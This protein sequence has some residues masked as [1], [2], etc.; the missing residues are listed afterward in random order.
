M[1]QVELSYIVVGIINVLVLFLF[2]K[3]FLF[4]RV[5]AVIEKRQ[6]TIKASLQEADDRK[7]EAYQLKE[8]YEKDI[9]Q[10]GDQAARIMKEA[11]ERAEVEYGKILGDA[12]AEAA[13]TMEENRKMIELERKRSLELA[14]SEIAD[15]A[16][17]AAARVIGR[18][19]ND[20]AN[21]KFLGD[22]LKEVGAE[23]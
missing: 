18:N 12:R 10:A 14:K 4:Q 7:T 5:G 13:R 8:N 9:S 2:L 17:L 3:I 16:L 23:K 21:Q 6:D 1:F 20:E 11:R 22:F 15:V 19:V